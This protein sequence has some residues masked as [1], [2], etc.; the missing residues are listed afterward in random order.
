MT[1]HTPPKRKT[2]LFRS[3]QIFFAWISP[4]RFQKSYVKWNRTGFPFILEKM[5]SWTQIQTSDETSSQSS[6]VNLTFQYNRFRRPIFFS[7]H[8]CRVG[9]VYINQI[10]FR[11]SIYSFILLTIRGEDRALFSD[12]WPSKLRS[13]FRHESW[14]SGRTRN[15]PEDNWQLFSTFYRIER[16]HASSDKPDPRLVTANV[17]I[18]SNLVDT[19][20]FPTFVRAPHH[21]SHL[22]CFS[23]NCPRTILHISLYA[24]NM[25]STK[26][27]SPLNSQFLVEYQ[28][29]LVFADTTLKQ[30]IAHMR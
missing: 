28:L 25:A 20:I 21:S 23:F 17:I 29:R 6:R 16:L 11:T 27:F 13:C 24:T 30:A 9:N 5:I 14:L 19:H 18:C 3:A 4:Q 22:Q 8:N 26:I 12:F 7:L 1:P 2:N 10:N 15:D